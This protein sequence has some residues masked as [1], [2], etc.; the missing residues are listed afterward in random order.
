M[1][2]AL[3]PA[4]EPC[5]AAI[6]PEELPGEL[7]SVRARLAQLESSHASLQSMKQRILEIMHVLLSVND[8]VECLEGTSSSTLPDKA[9]KQRRR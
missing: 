8:R 4:L 5:S 2:I 1:A 6:D 3:A 9:S 7:Q